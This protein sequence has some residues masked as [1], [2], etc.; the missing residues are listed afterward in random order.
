MTGMIS[1]CGTI[2]RF[3]N[4]F[5]ERSFIT[6][7]AVLDGGGGLEVSLYYYYYFIFFIF[8]FLGGGGLNF[9]TSSR[10]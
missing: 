4:V 6:W 5:R 8:Y 2:V 9:E 1:K 10:S 7:V 3:K